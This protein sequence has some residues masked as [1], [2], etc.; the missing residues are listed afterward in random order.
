M[1]LKIRKK[2]NLEGRKGEDQHQDVLNKYFFVLGLSHNLLFYVFI[3]LKKE[4]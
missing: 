4:L 2:V 1:H 3:W